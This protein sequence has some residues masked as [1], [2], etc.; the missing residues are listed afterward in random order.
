MSKR[1]SYHKFCMLPLKQR[2]NIVCKALEN[3]GYTFTDDPNKRDRQVKRALSEFQKN[4]GLPGNGTVCEESFDL[5]NISN[6]EV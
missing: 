3:T 6:M 5:L 2:W 1:L 4:N